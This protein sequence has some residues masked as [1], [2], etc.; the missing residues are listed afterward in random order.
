MANLEKVSAD[1]MQHRNAG[2]LMNTEVSG[3]LHYIPMTCRISSLQKIWRRSVYRNLTNSKL[4]WYSHVFTLCGD[5][6]GVLGE[7]QMNDF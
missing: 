2:K 4:G 6:R 7:G 3:L 5:Y 1:V